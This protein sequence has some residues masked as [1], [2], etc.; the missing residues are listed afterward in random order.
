MTCLIV[1]QVRI[2]VAKKWKHSYLSR[3][4]LQLLGYSVRDDVVMV[5]V[6]LILYCTSLKQHAP[7]QQKET[8]DMIEL[9][10]DVIL[11]RVVNP[12]DKLGRNQIAL[13]SITIMK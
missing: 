8:E 6:A 13:S 5:V 2:I 1:D 4:E 12:G 9:F 11:P 10:S 7:C 3:F